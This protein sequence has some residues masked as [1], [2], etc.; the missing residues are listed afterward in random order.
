MGAAQVLNKMRNATLNKTVIAS[1]DL[2]FM[3]QQA[4]PPQAA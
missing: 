1:D 2:N 3:Y 4:F